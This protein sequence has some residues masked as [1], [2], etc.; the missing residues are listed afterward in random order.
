[1]PRVDFRDIEDDE[2]CPHCG[3]YDLDFDEDGLLRCFDC[4]ELV[5]ES[6][7]PYRKVKQ[8]VIIPKKYRSDEL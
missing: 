3:S 6:D 8:K 2:Q 7:K 4:D 1:M 5:V